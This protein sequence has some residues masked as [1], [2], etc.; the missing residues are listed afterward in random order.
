MRVRFAPSPTGFL[1]IGNART[2][3]CNYL[4]ARKNN[5]TLLLRIEDTDME[6]SS[7]ESE[8]SILKDLKWLGI[9]WQEGPD[10]GGEYGPYRQSERFDI[11]REYSERLLR[12]GNAYHCYCSQDELDAERKKSEAEKGFYVYSGKCRDLSDEQKGA[13]EAEGRKPTIR[14]RVPESEKVVV[15]DLIKGPVAFSSENIGGDFIIVRSDGVPVYNYIV[16][17]DDTLMKVSHVIRGEDHLSNTPKQILIARA[18]D[19]PVPEYAHIAL[20]LGPDRAKLSKRHGITSVE[21]YRREGYLPEALFNYLAMLGWATESGEEI[22][23][24]DDIVRELEISSLAKSAAV[25]DFQKLRWM[26][27]MYI[28]NYP[29]DTITDLFLPYI[30]EAGYD[31]SGMD[32]TTLETIVDLLRGYCEVLGDITQYLGLFLED[33]VVPDEET[34][35]LMN[36]DESK[37]VVKA[38]YELIHSEI[39]ETNFCDDLIGKIKAA[40][41]LKGKKLFHPV[42]GMITG[43]LSGPE[44]DKAMPLFGFDRCRARIEYMY[45]RYVQG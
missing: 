45:K 10:A 29:L 40:T 33:V 20:V 16:I 3:I 1:H 5:A 25:F 4:V 36:E 8:V 14:F 34:D 38:A 28:R 26:N 2:A 35:A 21:M 43:R 37:Q 39:T 41:S 22:L 30:T 7:M 11:Y 42:R 12:D 13:F 23:S 32:R 15:N 19:L 44:L 24:V 18:L 6:R 27:G 9:E 17:I 31:V